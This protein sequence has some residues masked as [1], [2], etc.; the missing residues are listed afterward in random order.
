MNA[1]VLA[2]LLA[3]RE[4]ELKAATE[5]NFELEKV[6]LLLTEENSKLVS[7]LNRVKGFIYRERKRKVKIGFQPGGSKCRK[8]H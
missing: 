7:E 8:E 6:I 3:I 2:K 4:A 1:E 5:T